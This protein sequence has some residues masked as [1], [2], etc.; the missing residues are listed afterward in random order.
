MKTRARRLFVEGRF[1]FRER[2]KVAGD[3]DFDDPFLAMGQFIG[4]GVRAEFGGNEAVASAS[5]MR[6]DFRH[7]ADACP[8]APNHRYDA[9]SRTAIEPDRELVKGFVRR[10]VIRLAR[11]AEPAGDR[12]E[13]GDE[14]Q[15][16]D[17]QEPRQV[18]R[19]FDLHPPNAIERFR[20]FVADELVLD[21]PRGVNH[22]DRFADFFAPTS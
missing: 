3:D 16:I 2:S 20:T 10:G 5:E 7:H 22:T 12:R 17:R 1:Q 6:L 21:D 14:S 19:S 11:V 13:E 4:E 9:A 8:R 18:E 15:A